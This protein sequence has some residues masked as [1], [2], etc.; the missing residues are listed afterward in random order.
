MYKRTPEMTTGS[1]TAPENRDDVIQI[2]LRVI[3][4]L[5]MRID[6]QNPESTD[7]HQL[8][9]DQVRT[10]AQLAGQYRLLTRDTELDEIQDDL[11][12]LREAK[13]VRSED[14]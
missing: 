11:E 9:L 2:L 10:L 13:E 4:D 6:N 1:L 14:R 8:Y 3:G 5:A 12:L 7:E